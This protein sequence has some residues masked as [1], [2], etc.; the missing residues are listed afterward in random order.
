[1]S[2]FVGGYADWA[3]KP[4]QSAVDRIVG[5]ALSL[6]PNYVNLLGWAA[7]M[8]STSLAKGLIWWHSA[9]GRWATGWS[10]FAL[11][12]RRRSLWASRS[13]SR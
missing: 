3:S 11:R 13:V 6:H 5:D 2:E 4:G 8:P 12:I 9:C 10:R 7:A 1:M